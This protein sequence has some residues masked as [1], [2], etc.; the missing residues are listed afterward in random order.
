[1]ARSPKQAMSKYIGDAGRRSQTK[2]MSIRHLRILMKPL[3]R[4]GLSIGVF[5]QLLFRLITLPSK[6]Y[7][8]RGKSLIMDPP[9]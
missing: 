1:M 4:I 2:F 9:K 8:V 5:I 6:I 3:L 7:N